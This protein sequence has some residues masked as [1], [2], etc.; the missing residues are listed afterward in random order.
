MVKPEVIKTRKELAKSLIQETL[1]KG[2]KISGGV[3]GVKKFLSKKVE[4]L[5]LKD[6]YF[7]VLSDADLFEAFTDAAGFA[8][9]RNAQKAAVKPAKEVPRDLEKIPERS[10][11][12]PSIPPQPP[13]P[14][15]SDTDDENDP[16]EPDE[17]DDEQTKD[18]IEGPTYE[19][20]VSYPSSDVMIRVR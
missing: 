3:Q 13:T 2:Q 18:D 7:D 11:N 12:T 14:P 8:A 10:M 1:A 16:N 9:E 6:G 20:E 17:D 15:R 4:K 5:E 19:D